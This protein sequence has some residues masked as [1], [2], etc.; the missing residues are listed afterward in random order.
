[1]QAHIPRRS[2][3]HIRIVLEKTDRQVAFS[4]EQAPYLACHVIMIDCPVTGPTWFPCPAERTPF[5]LLEQ[6]VSELDGGELK[7]AEPL[8]MRRAKLAPAWRPLAPIHGA[9][10]ARL[11]HRSPSFSFARG[12]VSVVTAPVHVA[13]AARVRDPTASIHRAGHISADLRG[14]R[15]AESAVAD[16]LVM[17]PAQAP[18]VCLPSASVDSAP[19]DFRPPG[20]RRTR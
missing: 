11:I 1:M 9:H 10:L 15:M 5:P 6:Q 12:T 13:V 18:S 19:T 8:G 20:L 14:K 4:A 2:V 17:L 3:H 7:L 16:L